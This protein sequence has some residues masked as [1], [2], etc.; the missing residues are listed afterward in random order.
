MNENS[1]KITDQENLEDSKII[2]ELKNISINSD[3]LPS[4]IKALENF[5]CKLK[6]LNNV[7]NIFTIEVFKIFDELIKKDNIKI[8]LIL[9]R[10]CIDIISNDSLYNNYLMFEKDDSNRIDCLIRL[11]SDCS[12]IIEKLEGF[13]FDPELFKLKNK[14][15][16]LLKCIYF[17]CKNKISND[18]K[19]RMLEE[20]IESLPP[21]FYSN[22]FIELNKN[23][24]LYDIFKSQTLD[25]IAS[26]DD[27][28]MQVNNYF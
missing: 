22:A 2:Q 7:G 5:E 18:E 8:N 21:K 23:K 11:I 17:N 9:S 1:Q 19:L 13:V 26:F 12:S 25:K 14:T 28:F 6:S 3:G 24:Y 20:L 27:K 16:D 4:L 10:I 15:M